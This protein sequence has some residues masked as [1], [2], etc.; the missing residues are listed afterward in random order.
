MQSRCQYARNHK[1]GRRSG[2]IQQSPTDTTTHYL[3]QSSR[4]TMDTYD[5]IYW[6]CSDALPVIDAAGS[7]VVVVVVQH[8]RLLTT[9]CM[10]DSLHRAIL[11]SE[12]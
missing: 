6:L 7:G 11:D 8:D 12:Q 4:T 5:A 1:A 9:L 3:Q 10:T 2:I